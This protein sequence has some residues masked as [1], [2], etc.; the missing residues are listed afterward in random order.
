[1][2][3]RLLFMAGWR[4]GANT[5][6][7]FKVTQEKRICW[8]YSWYL[9]KELSISSWIKAHY[10]GER[11]TLK[12]IRNAACGHAHKSQEKTRHHSGKEADAE[13]LWPSPFTILFILRF[14]G[15]TT[16]LALQMAPEIGKFK[17]HR[18]WSA[19]RDRDALNDY[20]Q[21]EEK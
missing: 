10:W 16:S 15:L 8:F 14:W 4:T 19:L 7:F 9:T 17:R 3:H 21:H 11:I 12:Q 5:N 6:I 18:F 20:S 2:C 13:L 1:M